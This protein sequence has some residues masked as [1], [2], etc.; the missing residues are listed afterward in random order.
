MISA[1]SAVLLLGLNALVSHALGEDAFGRFSWALRLGLIGESL[2]DFGVHQITIRSIAREPARAANLFHNSLALKMAT[3]AAMFVVMAAAS[4]LA[5]EDALLWH[6]SLIMLGAA[7][8]RSF[9]LTV[10]GVLQG[11]ERFGHDCLVVV[12]DRVL[13]LGLSGLAIANGAGLL[14]VAGAFLLARVIA[15]GGAMLLVGSFTGGVRLRFDVALWRRL[16]REA[17]PLGLFVVVLNFYSYIDTLML[18]V[19]SD[20]V[21]T[22]L[23]NNAYG[24]YEGLSYAPAVLSAVLT[25]RL[26]R[27]WREDAGAHRRLALRSAFAAAALSAVAGG[28]MWVAGRPLLAIVFGDGAVAATTTLN[29]LLAGLPFVFVIWILHAVAI[30]VFRERLLLMTTLIGAGLN[31]ALNLVLIPRYGRDGAALATVI[32]EALTLTLLAVQLRVAVRRSPAP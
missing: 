18:G 28:A 26:S 15:V 32:G 19:M 22:G 1:A 10:R 4:W 14:G 7:I 3:G 27:L 29:V 23:Y 12:G 24:L 31:A 16:Q 17:I 30:S 21:Q 11:L 6:T 20:F 25:P 8:M 9:I 13:M 5:A 2:M